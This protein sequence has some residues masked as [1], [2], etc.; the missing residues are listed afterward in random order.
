MKKVV[1]QIVKNR[2]YSQNWQQNGVTWVGEFRSSFAWEEKKVCFWLEAT[3]TSFQRGKNHGPP[4]PS[5]IWPA[6]NDQR[7]WKLYTEL[8]LCQASVAGG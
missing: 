4:L 3:K 2:V 6:P 8:L 5:I 1:Q 7:Q